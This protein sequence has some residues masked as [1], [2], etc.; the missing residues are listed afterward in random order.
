MVSEYVSQVPDQTQLNKD[1]M[2]L[3]PVRRLGEPLDIGRTVVFL[4][5]E[6]AG[7]MTGQVVVVDGGRLAQLPSAAQLR[8]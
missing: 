4:A 3:H 8:E 1:L 5:S 6:D 2:E 7:F